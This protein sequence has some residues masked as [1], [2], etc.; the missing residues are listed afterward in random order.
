MTAEQKHTLIACMTTAFITT[1][2]GSSLNLAIPN[3]EAHFGVGASVVGW[4]VTAYMLAVSSMN[5]PL[6]KV[7]DAT[8]R[9]RMFIFAIAVFGFA[10][11]VGAFSVSIWML[12][13]MRLMQGF[14]GAMIFSTNNAILMSAFPESQRGSVLGKSTAATYIGLSAGPVIGGFL[15]GYLGWRSI[16]IASSL[17]AAAA[18]IIAVKGLPKR[19]EKREHGRFDMPGAM[20]YFAMIIMILY[21]LTDLSIARNARFVLAAGLCLCAVFVMVEKRADD[22]IIQ[23]EMFTKDRPFLCSNLAALLNYG[24]TFT[25]GYLLSIYLQMIM[26]FSSQAA[27][28]ILIVQ[29]AMQALFSPYMGRL[30]DRVPPHRLASGGMGICAAGLILL[31]RLTEGTPLAFVILI[32]VVMGFGFAMF[33]SPNVNAIMSRVDPADFGVANSI[34]A[35][36]RN[37]G[38][39]SSMAVVTI[40][41]GAMVGNTALANVP[42]GALMDA[43]HLI[44]AIFV[45]ICA[46]G[47]VLSLSRGKEK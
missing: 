35:T 14:A 38:Q 13:A 4:V 24:A 21:G 26:G 44:F 2:M 25:V 19:E 43:I 3:I 11:F 28:L 15:N 34:V 16:F 6:G 29:P 33:S 9:R 40:V 47:V 39:S 32:L 5:V 27:G 45:G 37:L 23:I 18:F 7:A 46:A 8:G 41:M 42:S 12:L 17:I 36:M 20:L 10:S 1:F 22:P 31:T 30:S